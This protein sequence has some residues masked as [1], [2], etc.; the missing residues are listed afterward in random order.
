MIDDENVNRASYDPTT[1]KT[2]NI[3]VGF[4]DDS[5]TTTVN[6]S[7]APIPSNPMEYYRAGLKAIADQNPEEARAYMVRAWEGRETLDD[8]TWP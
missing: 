3:Q 4:S 7:F 2:K 5:K 6:S 8:V 1:D